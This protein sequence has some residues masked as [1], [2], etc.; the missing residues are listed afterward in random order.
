M[1]VRLSRTT[2]FS[3]LTGYFSDTLERRPALLY[4]DMQCVV[5]FSVIPKCMTLNDLEWPFHVK[6]C[7]CA[8]LAG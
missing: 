7:F 8:G 5:I 1:M 2:I 4:N 3:V 6:F